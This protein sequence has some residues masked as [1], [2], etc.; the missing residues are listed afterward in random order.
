MKPRCCLLL[1][2]TSLVKFATSSTAHTFCLRADITWDSGLIVQ[3]FPNIESTEECQK[4]C[5]GDCHAITWLSPNSATFHNLCA[6]FSS[7]DQEIPCTDCVSGPPVCTCS[8]KGECGIEGENFIESYPNIPDE[9]SCL[10]ICD[11][12]QEC[13]FFAYF[14]DEHILQHLCLLFSSCEV[15][16]CQSD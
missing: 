5:S 7:T 3:T 6:L 1:V 14:S 11:E 9:A 12:T 2:L 13:N 4:L 15:G 16:N 10:E 8:E